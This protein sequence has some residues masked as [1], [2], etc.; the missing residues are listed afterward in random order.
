MRLLNIFKKKNTI[1]EG[2]FILNGIETSQVKNVVN[3]F[4]DFFNKEK[5]EIIIEIGTHLGG[6]S[7]WLYEQ[8]KLYKFQFITY[9][10]EDKL[11]RVRSIYNKVPFDFRMLNVCEN[12][13]E[14]EIETI[15]LSNKRCLIMCDGGDKI[16]EFNL[17]APKLKK[18]D[19]IMTHDYAPDKNYFKKH[20]NKKIWNWFESYDD[21][22]NIEDNNLEKIYSKNFIPVVWSCFKKR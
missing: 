9:D 3:V 17:F 19:F 15:L 8:S 10:I 20:I 12:P 13:G 6:F 16:K 5:F 4:P 7:S 21:A 11:W 18:G 2:F 22:L 1:V 14:K